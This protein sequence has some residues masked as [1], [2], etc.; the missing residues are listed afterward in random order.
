MNVT[1]SHIRVKTVVTTHTFKTNIA[2][3]LRVDIFGLM[4]PLNAV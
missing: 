4:C 1:M 2:A 3:G